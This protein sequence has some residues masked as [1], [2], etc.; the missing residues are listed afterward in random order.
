MG[1][2]LKRKP[3]SSPETDLNSMKAVR[4]MGWIESM[5]GS[6][7][8]VCRWGEGAWSGCIFFLLTCARKCGTVE[9]AGLE[10][11]GVKISAR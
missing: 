2:K 10:N 4:R 1:K 3:V 6:I 7:G 8:R 5:M 9:I 11:A